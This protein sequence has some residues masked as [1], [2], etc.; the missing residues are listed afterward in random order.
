VSSQEYTLLIVESPV[1]ADRLQKFAPQNV[2][3]IATK[4][5]LWSPL[6]V[7]STHQLN[8]KAIPSAANLRKELKEESEKAAKVIIATDSDPSGDFIAWSVCSSVKRDDILYRA[9]L[10]SLSRKGIEN[11]LRLAIRFDSTDLHLRLQNR[12]RIQQAWRHT[13]PDLSMRDA[14]RAVV[15]SS[16]LSY[17][18]FI[19]DDGILFRAMNPVQVPDME[20][21]IR[22]KRSQKEQYDFRFPPSLFDIISDCSGEKK[23]DSFS[24]IQQQLQTLF[25]TIHPDT[26]AGLITYPRT[27]ARSW[28]PETWRELLYQ[29]IKKNELNDFLPDLLRTKRPTDESHE[30]LRP[31]DINAHPDWISK[32]ITGKS[33]LIY[34]KIHNATLSAIMMPGKCANLFC[35][36]ANEQYFMTEKDADQAEYN[37]TPVRTLS[38]LGHHLNEL[39]VLRPSAFGEFLDHSLKNGTYNISGGIVRPAKNLETEHSVAEQWRELLIKLKSVADNG[40]TD[41]ETIRDIISSYG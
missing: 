37:L 33:A 18:H 40:D 39:G 26:G 17:T 19:S 35:T 12:Y 34:Q 23:F 22:V 30:A 20:N 15:F 11:L 5:F 29:W 10:T 13:F 6:Y 32:H 41:F 28:Y 24:E 4:G 27:A 38:D 1:I 25:E 2:L 31:V 14:G 9:N 7:P 8:K 21:S 16:A 3:V 36:V